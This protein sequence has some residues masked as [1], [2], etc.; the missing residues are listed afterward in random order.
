MKF[1]KESGFEFLKL[2]FRVGLNDHVRDEIDLSAD[3]PD[4]FVQKTQFI[5]N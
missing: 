3:D 1:D 4:L 5:R 2:E